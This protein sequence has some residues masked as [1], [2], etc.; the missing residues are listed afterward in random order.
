MAKSSVIAGHDDGSFGSP[1]SHHQSMGG[2]DGVRGTGPM[3]TSLRRG[4]PIWTP[5]I[6]LKCPSPAVPRRMR[7]LSRLCEAEKGQAPCPRG[8]RHSPEQI[9]R[10][11]R[12]VEASLAASR[13][14]GQLR[15]EIGVSEQT[16]YWEEP[17]RR[18]TTALADGGPDLP[19]R[20]SAWPALPRPHPRRRG[21]R[22]RARPGAHGRSGCEHPRHD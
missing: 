5:W 8:K 18:P 17:V 19:R 7:V 3:G 14:V 4:L 6:V 1:L 9:V 13:I 15:Q 2:Q 16:Y 10:H 11:L 20:L 12:D 22:P 21:P